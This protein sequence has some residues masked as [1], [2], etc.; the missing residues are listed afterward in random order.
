MILFHIQDGGDDEVTFN[1]PEFRTGA[2]TAECDN[3][4]SNTTVS[5]SHLNVSQSHLEIT[6]LK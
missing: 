3:E 5:I 4:C 6:Q 2:D 1:L